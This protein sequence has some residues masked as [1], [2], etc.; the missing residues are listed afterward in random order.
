VYRDNPNGG[1]RLFVPVRSDATLHWLDVRGSA[2]S[3]GSG[4]ELDCGQNSQHE[5]DANHRRG[6]DTSERTPADEEL[7]I[8]PFGI[9][10]TDDG[11]A[12][13]TTHQTEGQVALFVNDW[14]DPDAGPKLE[15]LLSGLPT[16]VVSAAAVPQ[17]LAVRQD[18]ALG[19]ERK[20]DYQPGFWV[21]YRG[22]SFVDLL[23][24]FDRV[25]ARN[26][27]PFLELTAQ[28]RVT[29]VLLTDIRGFGVDASTRNACEAACAADDAACASTCAA[30]P[31]QVFLGNRAPASLVSGHTVPNR[32]DAKSADELKLDDLAPVGSGPS[33]VVVG[34]ILDEQGLPQPRVFVVSFESRSIDIYDPALGD[35]EARIY[36]G[37]GP[38]ALALDAQHGLGYV[39]HFT[40][41]YIGVI[42]LDRRHRATYGAMILS[43]GR[44]VPPRGSE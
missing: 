30:L 35:V 42:D 39:A 18:R 8:E 15:F 9:A 20:L 19:V 36:T 27:G 28:E 4:R 44:P 37:R 34:S 5:C 40:D 3:P 6:D 17:S 31:L 25:D 32:T 24:Y 1:G 7:P 38:N 21:G 11:E 14:S 16:R 29:P 10:V 43:L 23:R 12:L 13:I 2:S 41:S 33:R 26:S 22:A